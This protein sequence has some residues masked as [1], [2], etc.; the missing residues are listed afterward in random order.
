MC[1]SRAY[2][3]KNGNKEMLLEEIISVQIDGKKLL[4]KTLFGEQKEL[5]ASIREI[6]F[7]GRSILLE[8]LE[9]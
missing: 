3:A 9:G 8:N 6:D 2:V 4:L 1:L 7:L 5:E